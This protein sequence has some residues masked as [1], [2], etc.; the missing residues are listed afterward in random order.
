MKWED[1]GDGS[2]AFFFVSCFTRSLNPSWIPLM[3]SFPSWLYR[4]SALRCFMSPQCQQ[5]GCQVLQHSV[6]VDCDLVGAPVL[7]SHKFAGGLTAIF[8]ASS[9]KAWLRATLWDL[10]SPMRRRC[11]ILHQHMQRVSWATWQG[12]SGPT[13]W[14]PLQIPVATR[15]SPGSWLWVLTGRLLPAGGISVC[16]TWSWHKFV[17][18]HCCITEQHS[19]VFLHLLCHYL[20]FITLFYH[21]QILHATSKCRLS[22][23]IPHTFILA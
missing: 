6:T 17:W 19:T 14:W 8:I 1:E 13:T 7:T 20:L 15:H 11:F 22:L 21:A 10:P 9:F 3:H 23:L 2:S 12:T 16:H 5:T 18:I 4:Q